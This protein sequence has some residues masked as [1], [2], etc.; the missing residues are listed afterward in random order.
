MRRAPGKNLA[1][2]PRISFGEL[3][4]EMTAADLVLARREKASLGR[5]LKVFRPDLE[6]G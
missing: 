6:G 4:D 5:G 1:G 3:V 2:S